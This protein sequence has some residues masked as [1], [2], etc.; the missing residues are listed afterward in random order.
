[1]ANERPPPRRLPPGKPPP[2]EEPEAEG[3][4]TVPEMP[5]IVVPDVTQPRAKMPTRPAP[6]GAPA[7]R[8]RPTG[9]PPPRRGRGP[10]PKKGGALRTV[11]VV[12]LV[13]AVAGGG[14]GFY[15]MK[16]HP[17]QLPVLTGPSNKELAAV[18]FQHG[19]NLARE[20][21]WS[22]AKTR[23]EEVQSLDA[24]LTGLAD[25][26]K[27]AAVEIPN[28]EHLDAAFVALDK[29]QLGMAAAEL[30]Q[31]TADTVQVNLVDKARRALND[32][33]A[34][35]LSDGRALL[36]SQ[37]DLAAQRKLEATT[38]DALAAQPD[39]RDLKA[40]N[41]QARDNIARLTHKAVPVKGPEGPGPWV[42]VAERFKSGDVGGAFSL[43][44]A[45]AE[46][47]A[48]CRT[49]VAQVTEFQEL[50]K[51]VEQL[52]V[53]G[54]EKLMQLDQAICGG[55]AAG[56]PARTRLA[57]G[58]YRMAAS[59]NQTA[60]WG[61]AWEYA[62]KVLE[63]DRG[64][65]GAQTIANEVKTRANNIFMLGYESASRGENDE[66]LKRFKECTE[67]SLASD[68]LHA[69]C[70]RRMEQLGAQ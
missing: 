35:C 10:E 67:M 8:P 21:K 53:K 41:D 20:G 66:A 36:G 1:M 64:H 42:E 32:K 2:V 58:Y 61:R 14:A 3:G 24:E 31:V 17:K 55:G 29:T 7:P 16:T 18:A 70:K 28:Q 13:L 65:A 69:K 23:F 27:R 48:N 33:V 9:R 46:A 30:K 60:Q 56:Q 12:L 62:A 54:L 34:S 25:Y 22:E 45:C 49:L 4:S 47:E 51:K 43:A 44:N 26:L 19:K 39:N 52:E 38:A 68:E 11:L 5:A 15:W 59:A 6:R 57:T 40:L 50:N 37:N 63:L